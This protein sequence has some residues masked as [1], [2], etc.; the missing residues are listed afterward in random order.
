VRLFRAY[1]SFETSSESFEF[2]E[3]EKNPQ[4]AKTALMD[5]W[6]QALVEDGF[7]AKEI[8]AQPSGLKLKNYSMFS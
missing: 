8:V 4:I 6:E 5:K 2:I 1:D 7:N 3:R